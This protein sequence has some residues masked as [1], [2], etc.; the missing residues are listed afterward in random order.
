MVKIGNQDSIQLPR[1]DLV[2]RRDRMRK[3]RVTRVPVDESNAI[4]VH[5]PQRQIR[6]FCQLSC[7][8]N[9]DALP[10]GP[11]ER[12]QHVFEPPPHVAVV[13]QRILHVLIREAGFLGKSLWREEIADPIALNGGNLDVP[14]ARQA[15]EIQVSLT[16]GDPELG[17]ERALRSP[18]VAIELA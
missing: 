17:R 6:Q 11:F 9:R 3:K 12:G 13:G 7:A 15:L 1:R 10:F 16:K 4:D 5:L 2:R 14:F 8:A 18:A